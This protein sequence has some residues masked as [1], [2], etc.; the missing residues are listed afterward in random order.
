MLFISTFEILIDTFIFVTIYNGRFPLDLIKVT[1]GAPLFSAEESAQVIHQAEEE[2]VDKNEYKSGKYKL[3]GKNFCEHD[4]YNVARC[5][6]DELTFLCLCR[7]L[8][9]KS[10]TNSDLVQLQA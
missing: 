1:E 9:S 6:I 7:R 10:P 4:L 8:A 2:G 3:G 5:C